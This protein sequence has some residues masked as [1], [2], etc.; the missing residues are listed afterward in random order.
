MKAGKVGRERHVKVPEIVEVRNR[1]GLSRQQFAEVLGV[2]PRTLEG[3]EQER[4]KPTGAA[5]SLL[6]IAKRPPE[7]LRELFAK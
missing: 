2:S 1:A 5:R 3:W 7:V 6:A 4:R